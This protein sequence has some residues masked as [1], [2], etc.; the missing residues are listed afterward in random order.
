MRQLEQRR[1]NRIE[2]LMQKFGLI[3]QRKEIMQVWGWN[4]RR[5]K[6]HALSHVSD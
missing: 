6:I 2:R 1:K 5:R 3:G 4:A